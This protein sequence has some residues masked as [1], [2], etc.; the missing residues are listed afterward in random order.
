MKRIDIRKLAQ[1]LERRNVLS[2]NQGGYRAGQIAW[3]NAA[4]FVYD[5]YEGFQR[6]EQ[7]M[8]VAVDL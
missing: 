6:K 8:A 2:P 3:K 7:T 1:D 4:R 5:I